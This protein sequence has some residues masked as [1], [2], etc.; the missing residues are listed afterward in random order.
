MGIT[1]T[2]RIPIPVSTAR[3]CRVHERVGIAHLDCISCR[4]LP[5]L[6]GIQVTINIS[7]ATHV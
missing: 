1:I 3:C 6:P 7:I 2:Y 5:G 4:I